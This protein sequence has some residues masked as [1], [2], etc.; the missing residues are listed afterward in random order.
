MCNGDGLLVY[1]GPHW[2][3]YSSIQFEVIRDGVEDY[4]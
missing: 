1:P 4:E 3:P 2:T